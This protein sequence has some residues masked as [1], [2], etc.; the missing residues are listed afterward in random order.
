[1][2]S[3]HGYSDDLLLMLR[4]CLQ[5]KPDNRPSTKQ[6]LEHISHMKVG[7]VLAFVCSVLLQC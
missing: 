5:L 3:G 2:P 6:L 4:R 1:M 7:M